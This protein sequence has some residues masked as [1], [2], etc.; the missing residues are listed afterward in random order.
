MIAALSVNPSRKLLTTGFSRSGQP[1]HHMTE[2]APQWFQNEICGLGKT[3]LLRAS[4]P[5]VFT[6]FLICQHMPTSLQD[7]ATSTKRLLHGTTYCETLRVQSR[8]ER[9]CSQLL[10]R[11]CTGACLCSGIARRTYY[12]DANP[13]QTLMVRTHHV[14]R[15]MDGPTHANGA[16]PTPNLRTWSGKL[17][18]ASF[19]QVMLHRSIKGCIP[20]STGDMRFNFCQKNITKE[21][22]DPKFRPT[23]RASCT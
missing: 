21:K 15:S 14:I 5:L 19:E 13:Q 3:P 17:H 10:R 6:D 23:F 4:N 11:Y 16:S 9:S 20:W 12:G 2:N 8:T 18:F 7:P 22:P 1:K